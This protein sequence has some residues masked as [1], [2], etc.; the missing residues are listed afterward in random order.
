[1]ASN[2]GMSLCK[3]CGAEYR[4]FSISNRDMQGLTKAW[5]QRHERSCSKRTP[6][7]RMKWAKPYIGKTT[8][9]SSITVDLEH[10]GF[11]GGKGS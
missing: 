3:H 5:K 1:M 7:Q 10:E 2:L 6:E 11:G 9:D 8:L 4:L